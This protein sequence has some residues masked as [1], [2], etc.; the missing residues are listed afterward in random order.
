[1]DEEKNPY[2]W[3]RSGAP[4]TEI[5]ELERALG[6]FRYV[7]RPLREGAPLPRDLASTETFGKAS[8]ASTAGI[9]PRLLRRRVLGFGAIAAALLVGFVAIR[10]RFHWQTGQ[11]WKVA[12][13]AGSP[14]VERVVV[15][16][17]G[18]LRVGQILETDGRSRARLEIGNIGTLTVEPNSRVRL[19]AT[20]T[21]HHRIAL[22]Y[23]S[24][25][26]RTWAPP[27]TFAID[28]ASS[29]LFDL[30]CAFTLRMDR[31]GSGL[32]RVDAGWVQFELGDQQSVVPAGAE[33]ITRPNLGPGTPCFQ[34]ARPEFKAALATFDTS[35]E[36]SDA[37][38]RAID[39][40]LANARPRD[41][42][43]LMSLLP[44]VD[45]P[46]RDRVLDV[47]ARFVP[48]PKGVTREQILDLQMK[49]MD[50]YWRE[51]GLGNPKSWLMHWR[52]V[53]GD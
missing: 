5:A 41:A 47:L 15:R 48:I 42:I 17:A 11:A 49:A 25:E 2:L 8:R 13:I 36:G 4:D 7:P 20:R 21:R 19:L 16:N 1:M 32:V 33:A 27:F 31:E 9:S 45:R 39:V 29:S 6:E 28:T 18:E 43:T 40:L 50:R 38:A 53:I 3:D 24:I 23:G 30:G 51:L 44:K 10:S 35:P 12:T 14:I 34:D 22:D 52:D 46:Q 37:R 26:A